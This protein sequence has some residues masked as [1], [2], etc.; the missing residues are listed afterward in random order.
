MIRQPSHAVDMLL[1]IPIWRLLQL[2]LKD[3]PTSKRV[4]P[5]MLLHALRLWCHHV[6]LIRM[7]IDLHAGLVLLP[8][9]RGNLRSKLRRH[10]E[11][12]DS[13]LELLAD[14]R[15]LHMPP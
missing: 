2:L 6:W 5:G 12:I 9:F 1:L 4:C 3:R 8:H 10:R 15:Y 14:W 11:P 7:L 13:L